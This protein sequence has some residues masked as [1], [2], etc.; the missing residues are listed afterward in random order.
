[1]KFKRY[2]TVAVGPIFAFT[3]L[4]CSHY[5]RSFFEVSVS[6]CWGLLRSDVVYRLS[7]C[8]FCATRVVYA[9]FRIIYIFAK[10]CIYKGEMK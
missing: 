2:Q 8:H 6:S 5:L 4:N 7:L 10:H 1:M 9:N 3:L